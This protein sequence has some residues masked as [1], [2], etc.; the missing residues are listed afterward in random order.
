MLAAEGLTHKVGK[1][2]ERF[3]PGPQLPVVVAIARQIDKLRPVK[4]HIAD[5][6]A[7]AR[8]VS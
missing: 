7:V 2:A 8:L 3:D 6:A 4:Q 5:A 1:A